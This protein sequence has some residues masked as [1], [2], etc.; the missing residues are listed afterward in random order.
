MKKLI[1]L[2]LMTI[3]QF[4]FAERSSGYLYTTYGDLVHG[5]YGNCI[6]T[7]YYDPSKGLA[8]CGE[9]PEVEVPKS[10]EYSE[11]QESSTS[12]TSTKSQESYSK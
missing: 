9:S 4:V 5:A 6:H 3:I 7:A 8:E 12:S 10:S 2:I 1:L 11:S